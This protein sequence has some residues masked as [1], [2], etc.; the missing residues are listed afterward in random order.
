MDHIDEKLHTVRIK[1]CG[2]KAAIEIDGQHVN[3]GA[4]N[5]YTLGHRDGE[6]PQVVLYSGDYVDAAF[7]GLARVAVADAPDPG[8]AAAVFLAAIDAEELERAAL[9]RPDLGTGPHSL[10]EAMLLQLREWANGV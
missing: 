4:L 9:S 3:P 2:S 10:T 5:G 8:P 1:A 7:E 6:L